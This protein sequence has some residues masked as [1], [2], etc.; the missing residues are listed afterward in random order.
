MK[1]KTLLSLAIVLTMILAAAP[2]LAVKGTTI[3]TT[4]SVVLPN[5]TQHQQENVGNNYV[6][7]ITINTN[8][9][10]C[11]GDFD[12]HIAWNTS[13]LELYNPKLG[14][15]NTTA[16]ISSSPWM[17]YWANYWTGL[18]I[19]S[20][21]IGGVPVGGLNVKAGTV[22]VAYGLSAG[23]ATGSGT[24][25]QMDFHSMSPGTKDAFI[26]L[27]S[28][29]TSVGCHLL[30]GSDNG[31]VPI[32]ATFNGTVH[33][34]VPLSTPPIAVIV[35]PSNLATYTV[36]ATVT[37]Q[38][39]NASSTWGYA[40]LPPPGTA[41]QI[42][43]CTW[44]YTITNSSGTYGPYTP[45]IINST[46]SSFKCTSAGSVSITLTVT[47]PAP[48]G[49][50]YSDSV[51][52]TSSASITIYQMAK[53][54]G[55]SIDVYT[56]R[57]GKGILGKYPYPYGWSDA[58]A[59]Q[60]LVCVYGNV[61]YNGAP[62]WYKPVE[63]VV[64]LPNGTE[65]ASY[66]AFTNES[67]IAKVCFRIPWEANQGPKYFGNMSITGAVSISQ[68][69]VNDTVKFPYGWILDINSVTIANAM[70]LHRSNALTSYVGT[71]SINVTLCSIETKGGPS[72]S[73][74]LQITAVDN[75]SVPFGQTFADVTVPPTGCTTTGLSIIIPEWAY[76]GSG[77]LYVDLLNSNSTV[78]GST[79]I[80]WCPEWT[81]P[82]TIVYP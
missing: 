25:F 65:I 2:L 39:L 19:S 3:V 24:M 21:T 1:G 9:T 58:Y 35:K 38:A 81:Q 10:Q 51:P 12:M 82:F 52:D 62:V 26:N 6:V 5:G 49:Y 32:T 7:N 55:P 56:A 78:L 69:V 18:G 53:A 31:P 42:T 40:S 74:F 27:T 80:P 50:S 61:T 11:V 68:V 14:I 64:Y 8:N 33:I 59:P 43:L 46:A 16:S 77:T 63:F 71:M 67:G 47:A 4:C 70:S 60:E 29:N 72:H 17:T 23:N 73:G 22:E 54:V 41:C 66:E 79:A 36:G 34:P 30:N 13:M 48:T 15:Y 57:G 45:T 44:T 37:L 28:P 76:V 75:G 20:S